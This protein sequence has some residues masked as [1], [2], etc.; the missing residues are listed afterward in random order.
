[1]KSPLSLY[2]FLLLLAPTHIFA[3]PTPIPIN[4]STDAASPDGLGHGGTGGGGGAGGDNIINSIL[5]A[6]GNL[7]GIGGAI[8]TLSAGLTTLEQGLATALGIQTEEDQLSCA[9]MS[10]IFAR[11]T[12]EPGN[13]G[14]LTG[15]EFF[16][17]LEATVGAQ[18]VVVQGVD[19]SASIDGF[20]EGGDPAGSQTM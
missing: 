5:L 16:T 15:P 12:T 14:V 17:A 11:G 13:V 6:V 4:I 1:M 20:L 19:Y 3:T 2:I 10:V 8:D 7:P 9:A 18:N